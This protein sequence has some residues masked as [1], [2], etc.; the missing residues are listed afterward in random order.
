M[1]L[2]LFYSRNA[3][4]KGFHRSKTIEVPTSETF[5][6]YKTCIELLD[7]PFAGEPGRQ[8]SVRIRA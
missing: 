7:E 1:S 2:R 6:M 5:V 8:L 3:M 4:T